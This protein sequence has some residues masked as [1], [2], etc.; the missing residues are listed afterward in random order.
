MGDDPKRFTVIQGGD[1]PRPYHRRGAPQQWICRTCET[2]TGVATSTL[3]QLWAAPAF[4]RGKLS[5]GVKLWVCLS[6]LLRGK[7]TPVV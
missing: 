2:D 1:K 6:C 4:H 5:G 7:H 3:V